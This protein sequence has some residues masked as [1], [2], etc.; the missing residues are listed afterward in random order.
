VANG[1]MICGG[2]TDGGK[3]VSD[4]VRPWQR[5]AIR[6]STVDDF[7]SLHF[8]LPQHLGWACEQQ[9]DDVV[10]F[11]LQQLGRWTAART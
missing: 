9:Q 11:P 3:A 6:M 2:I 7:L 5:W 4:E 1:L 8:L 10:D